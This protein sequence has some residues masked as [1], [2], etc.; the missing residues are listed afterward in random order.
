[1]EYHFLDFDYYDISQ[2]EMVGLESRLL[3]LNK[4]KLLILTSHEDAEDDNAKTQLKA[5]LAA[6]KFDM[7]DDC[8]VLPFKQNESIAFQKL[9]LTTFDHLI[10]FGISPKQI[11][12]QINH[13]N[14]TSLKILNKS[15]LFA[16]S[17]SS[18][19]NDVSKKKQLWAALQSIFSS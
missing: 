16:D 2:T 14:Y 18:I 11:G 5:I 12:L 7:A 8:A 13:Y 1:M 17:I 3:G 6:I 4:K 19:S 9:P 15:L 10:S